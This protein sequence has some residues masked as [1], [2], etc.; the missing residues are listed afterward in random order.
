MTIS[1]YVDW[2]DDGNYTGEFD[3][4]SADVKNL[5]FTRGR[6][7]ELGRTQA[8][9]CEFVVR[10]E[11]GKYSPD[12]QA[13]PIYGKILP[14]KKVQVLYEGLSGTVYLFTGFINELRPNPRLDAQDC[15][16]YLVDGM[17]ALS[18]GMA[19][20]ALQDNISSGKI[21]NDILDDAGWPE[22]NRLID[23]G[24]YNFPWASVSATS[25]MEALNQL[26]MLEYGARCFVDGQGNFVWQ[27]ANYRPAI[28]DS[29]LTIDNT[30]THIESTF[31]L[32][33]VFNEITCDFTP[34]A[35]LQPDQI[36][37]NLA[38][39]VKVNSGQT[40]S[41]YCQ[42]QY[43]CKN[44]TFIKADLSYF[45]ANTQPDGHGIEVPNWIEVDP[46]FT[47]T[48]ATMLITNIGGY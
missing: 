43:P 35:E 23:T 29:T 44:A 42:Y 31:N 28:T 11:T 33:N 7:A 24:A 9:T 46:T 34:D 17:D 38:N 22:D 19:N 27:D 21:V 45:D 4:I 25:A 10:N 14:R 18:R 2:D 39:P 13:S 1:V 12:N 37:Y 3:D 40:V 36:I 47:A 48:S 30:N 6:D 5:N 32:L 15:Y 20:V 16:V 8:G 41:L 26:E